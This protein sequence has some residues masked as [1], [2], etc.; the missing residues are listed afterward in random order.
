MRERMASKNI[1]T[2]FL[3][4]RVEKASESMIFLKVLSVF[5]NFFKIGLT[6]SLNPLPSFLLIF[7]NL[8]CFLA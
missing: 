1:N 4:K 8:V 5:L 7:S 2:H 6:S 3:E